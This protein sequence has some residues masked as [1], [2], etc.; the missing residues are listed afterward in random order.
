MKPNTTVAAAFV[1]FQG[2][3]A[4]PALSFWK[5]PGLSEDI[6]RVIDELDPGLMSGILSSGGLED[7]DVQQS[8]EILLDDNSIGGGNHEQHGSGN[9][10]PFRPQA[11]DSTEPPDG[12]PG[13]TLDPG[14]TNAQPGI[15]KTGDDITPQGQPGI[16]K[17]GD[18]ITPQGQEDGPAAEMV[19]T[20]D[21]Y[22]FKFCDQVD[23]YG[24]T[25]CQ[26]TSF[27]AW[28]VDQRLH[29]PFKQLAARTSQGQ[30][31][32]ANN[33]AAVASEAGILVDK[34]PAPGS[35]AQNSM[36]D[37]GHVA[38]VVGVEGDS[39]L[40]EDYNGAGGPKRYGKAREPRSKYQYIHF[41][42]YKQGR[43]NRV[44]A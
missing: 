37:F 34:Q 39:V 18:D 12:R 19:K 22:P 3:I 21:D 30:W 14:L 16:D 33:W 5:D 44:G 6:T 32:D 2:S 27:A 26:C 41:E 9:K 28:R 38:W 15:D 7:G 31:G 29:L 17:T 23:K 42:K 13:G 10:K 25:S 8:I 43:G 20:G 1:F 35:V 11:D 4:L 40:I 36:G 24:V